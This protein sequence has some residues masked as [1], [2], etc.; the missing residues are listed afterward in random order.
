MFPQAFAAGLSGI[1]ATPRSTGAWA[2][3]ALSFP[4]KVPA[5]KGCCKPNVPRF[6]SIYSGLPAPGSGARPPRSYE[7]LDPVVD[8]VACST[9]AMRPA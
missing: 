1:D 8:A 9:G 4:R 5:G 2:M 3:C 7:R 6:T